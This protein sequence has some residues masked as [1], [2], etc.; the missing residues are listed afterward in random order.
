MINMI[1]KIKKLSAVF[2]IIFA[3]VLIIA[4]NNWKA[5]LKVKRICVTGNKILSADEVIKLSGIQ[6]GT[7]IYKISLTDI[8]QKLMNYYYIKDVVVQ[9]YFSNIIRVHI[10]ERLP[11]AVLINST[12]ITYVDDEGMVLPVRTSSDIFDLPV[13]SGFMSDKPL[14]IGLKITNYN[15]HEILQL[16][17]LMKQANRPLYHNISEAQ[18]QN[19]GDIILFTTE[20]TVPVIFGQGDIASKLVY[21][22]AF[23]N[24]IIRTQGLQNLRYI[25]LRYNGQIVACWN[26]ET[27]NSMNKTL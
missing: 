13:I 2:L 19:D 12:E 16:L 24:T 3:L 23:W 20:S 21:L 22:E 11:L 18:L 27:S 4:A 26:K 14:K 10:T 1:S 8:Q 6:L 9:R 7:F 15:F 5:H 17:A 25:D